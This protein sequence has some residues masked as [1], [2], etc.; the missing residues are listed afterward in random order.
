MVGFRPH[1]PIHFFL[2]NCVYFVT[3]GTAGKIC[4]LHN[5]D[6]KQIFMEVLEESIHRF[7]ME[8]LGWVLLDNHYHILIRL[9]K[10]SLLRGFIQNLHSNSAR[11]LNKLERQPGRKLWWNYWDRCMRNEA[12]FYTHLNYIHHNC[13]KHRYTERLEDYRW[14]SYR[15]YLESYGNAWLESCFARY[16]IKDF[17]PQGDD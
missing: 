3:A 4:A 2:D 12:D 15:E 14:S 11:L 13:V 17:T 8:L 6:Q 7:D 16:P 5:D 10:A 9:E 1:H